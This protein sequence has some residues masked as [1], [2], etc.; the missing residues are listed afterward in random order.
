MATRW[1]NGYGQRRIQSGPNRGAIVKVYRKARRHRI[2]R[3]PNVRTGGFVGIER[4]FVDTQTDSDAFAT[5][6]ATMEDATLDSV[7]G[8]AQGNGE[9]QRIG[10]VVTLQSIHIRCVVRRVT[11]EAQTAPIDDVIGRIALV[12]D[13]QTNAAQM[14]ATDCM[15]GGQTNDVLAFRNLQNSTRFRVYWDKKWRLG[16]NS[17]T[18]EGVVNSFAIG[19][20]QTAVMYYNKRFKGGIKV[21]YNST[22][23]DG[24]I[25]TVADNSLHIIGVGSNAGALLDMQVRVRFTG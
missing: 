11:L 5:T 14:T 8:I 18:N 3:N 13:T 19:Q 12:L 23:T 21:K 17:Q 7:S 6:W 10:R 25:S 9:S 16:S 24:T 4:K 20:S 2:M 1:R 22:A 15:D